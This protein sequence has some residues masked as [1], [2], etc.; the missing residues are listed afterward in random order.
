MSCALSC[1]LLKMAQAQ[2][3]R[4][5]KISE[6]VRTMEETYSFVVSAESLKKSPVLQAIVE[7]ISKQTI[8]CGFFIQE[9]V[10]HSFGGEWNGLLC[11]K[12]SRLILEQGGPS[13][14][15]SQMQMALSPSFAVNL[16]ASR[17]ILIQ[18]LNLT[19]PWF[20]LVLCLPLMQSVC[21]ILLRST[22]CC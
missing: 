4:D 12:K 16:G 3:V 2:Q 1:V 19:L 13:H 8:E 5:E 18:G 9:Y 10:R 20:C 15:H 21:I 14:S 17:G 7:Q 11:T 6:L 22:G